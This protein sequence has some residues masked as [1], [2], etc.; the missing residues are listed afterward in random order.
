LA[1]SYGGPNTGEV[2]DTGD[3]GDAGVVGVVGDVGVVCATTMPPQITVML[4][5]RIAF[6]MAIPRFGTR[7]CMR[8]ARAASSAVRPVLTGLCGDLAMAPRPLPAHC[9]VDDGIE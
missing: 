4:R 5:N 3:V 8:R 9:D 6:L 2:G 1:G 7:F